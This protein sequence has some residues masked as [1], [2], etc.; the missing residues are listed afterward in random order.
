LAEAA[1]SVL[2]VL[3]FL[4]ALELIDTYK[5]LPARRVWQTI[6][7]GTAAAVVCFGVN[8]ALY[9][10]GISPS[11]WARFG[12]P[13]LE[14]AAKAVW[15]FRLIRARRIGFMGDAAI[16]GFAVGAGFAVLEN[17]SYLPDLSGSALAGA[18]LRGF[19]TAM[20][21]G[22]STAIFAVFAINRAEMGRLR[23]SVFLPGFV[24]AVA[25]HMFYNQP[26]LTPLAKAVSLLIFLPVLLSVIFWRSEKA[27]E[28]W[29][30]VKLD[31]DIDLLQMIATGEF[32]ASHAGTY[33]RSLESAFGPVILGD[34]LCYLHLA[35][36][37]SAQA[38][39]DLLRR[40]ME[41]PVEP[42]PEW[43]ARLKELRYLEK[44]IGR[45]GKMALAPLLGSSYREVWDFQRL[46]EF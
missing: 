44:Q 37:L 46:S 38:K 7:A 23:L 20:M 39:G 14:E 15:V 34:M 4:F 12:A 31:K 5:L 21:H 27:L 24:I 16:S 10:A 36:E 1:I 35:L 43:P 9:A 3:V 8:T 26:V 18:A 45:A 13:V 29:V 41:F 42:D 22:G 19:G 17:L 30:G 32:N 28:Q 6:A 2:P 40:E 33:L 25:M 11:L